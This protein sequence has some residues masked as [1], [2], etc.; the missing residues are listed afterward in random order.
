MCV[1]LAERV[2]CVTEATGLTSP[3]DF[4]RFMGMQS[5]ERICGKGGTFRCLQITDLPYKAVCVGWCAEP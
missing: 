4:V 1:C 5:P 2:C 3:T